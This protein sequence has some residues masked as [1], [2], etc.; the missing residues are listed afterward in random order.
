[1]E[2][3]LKIYDLYSDLIGRLS[4]IP[5]PTSVHQDSSELNAIHQVNTSIDLLSEASKTDLS[6]Y[7][8]EV[9][10]HSGG[11]GYS[12][13]SDYNISTARQNIK[14]LITMLHG[15]YFSEQQSPFSTS[16]HTK[17]DLNQTQTQNQQQ[18]INI[19]LLSAQEKI[20]ELLQDNTIEPNEKSF[21]TEL[22]SNLPSI[23]SLLQIVHLVLELGSKFGITSEKLHTLAKLIFHY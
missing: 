20:N 18:T 10:H 2:N 16:P 15:K 14:A 19:T 13:Y 11:D 1:M 12:S 21:L 8:T 6:R 17:I 9:K 22:K 4:E 7:K 23:T 5:T 3:K